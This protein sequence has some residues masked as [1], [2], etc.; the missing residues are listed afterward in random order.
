[1]GADKGKDPFEDR[2]GQL[3]PFRE[4][5]A[6]LGRVGVLLVVTA[7]VEAVLVALDIVVGLLL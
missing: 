6:S 1:M 2:G 4:I 5:T 3:E 7:I